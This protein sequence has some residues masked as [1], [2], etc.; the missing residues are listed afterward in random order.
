MTTEVRFMIRPLDQITPE[1]ELHSGGKAYNCARLKQAGFRVPDGIVV[2]ATASEDDV[3]AVSDHPWFDALPSDTLFAVRSSGIG[4]DSAGQSFAGIH[5]TLLDVPRA[6]LQ[7]T[8]ITCRES[9]LSPQAL[10]YRRAK[11][12]PLDAIQMGVLIQC[13]VHPIAAGVAFTVNPVTGAGNELVINS[14]W[15]VG[16]ALVSGQVD[17]DEFVVRKTD[18]E[19]LWTRAGGKG[20]EETSPILSLTSDQVR[21]LA[22]ILM[23]IERHYG[24]PQDVEWCHDES[25][26]WIVQS[27]PITTGHTAK[28]GIEWT[29]ANLAEVLPDLTSPQA[30]SAF[31]QMLNQAE[32][33]YL[34]KLIQPETQLGPVLKSFCGRLYF[35][36]SQMRHLC[37]LLGERPANLLRSMGHAET[38]Q[39]ADE[40]AVPPSLRAL[41]PAMPDLIR[42]LWRHS[43]AARLIHRHE[44]RTERDLNRLKA[45]NAQALPDRELW[46]L[47]D[48]WIR[49]APDYVQTVL[50]LGGVMVHETPVRKDL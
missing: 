8:V 11:G 18:T 27:R 32:Q 33:R 10:E 39:P 24:T 46:K 23:E 34:E 50:L 40:E 29:R 13:M 5:Q 16:E 47:V 36:L 44:I 38:I 4:E 45:E 30:L 12:L 37:A 25:E 2:P 42:V 22:H 15:G 26:F 9:A 20:V 6:G 35:N 21:E 41:L 14:S 3:A 7:R 28:T 31:E 43:R 17:P 19:L 49:E 48:E 1:D